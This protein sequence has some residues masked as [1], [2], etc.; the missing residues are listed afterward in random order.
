MFEDDEELFLTALTWDYDYIVIENNK[1]MKY[2]DTRRELLS[3]LKKIGGNDKITV[4]K[5]TNNWVYQAHWQF[6]YPAH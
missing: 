3:R 1:F 5:P 6:F 2:F 4:C